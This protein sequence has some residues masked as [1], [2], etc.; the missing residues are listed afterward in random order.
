M[1]QED[2]CIEQ[3]RATDRTLLTTYKTITRPIIEYAS[4]IWGPIVSQSNLEKLQTIQNS[5][6]RIAT[7]CTRDTNAQH[8]HEESKILP[9]KEHIKLHSSI[10]RQK[11]QLSNHPL[12]QLNKQKPK[13]RNLKETIFHNNNFT[14]NYDDNLNDFTEDTV[15]SNKTKIHTEIVNSYLKSKLPNKIIN[16]T[17]PEINKNEINIS[18]ESRRILAQLRSNKC[19][20]LFQYSNKIN[21]STYQNPM[22]PL[23]LTNIHDT[24]HLFNCKKIYSSRSVISLWTEPDYVVSLLARWRGMGGL[25]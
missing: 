19:P 5:S 13:S 9:I 23:C 20:I 25:P 12:N 17:A 7:G 15:N 21:P 3:L 6:L 14:T 16:D 8:L 24:H 11:S 4:T 2:G 18:R 10:L 22:C 1:K